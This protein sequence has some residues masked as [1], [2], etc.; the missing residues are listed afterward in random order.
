MR[1]IVLSLAALSLSATGAFAQSAMTCWY[2]SAGF[3]TGRDGGT[4]GY[5]IGEVSR[6]SSG[7]F[8]FVMSS[9]EM[10]THGACPSKVI[11]NGGG[12]RFE[13]HQVC[14]YDGNGVFDQSGSNY[15]HLSPG[16]LIKEDD[17]YNEIWQLV[18]VSDQP[19]ALK[20]GPQSRGGSCPDAQR[21]PG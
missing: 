8:A 17:P 13:Y 9:T 1:T 15:R 4:A 14:Y 18:Q 7:G 20:A 16:Q 6:L 11:L 5:E 21:I 12:Y 2:N 10:E 19:Y 3:S